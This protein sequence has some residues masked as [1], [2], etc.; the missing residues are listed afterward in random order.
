MCFT[1]A[2][3]FLVFLNFAR[4]YRKGGLRLGFV[5]SEGISVPPHWGRGIQQAESAVGRRP[6]RYE[7]S[8]LNPAPTYRSAGHNLCN[9]LCP[10]SLHLSVHLS[11]GETL[12]VVVHC[13]KSCGLINCV[14][15]KPIS[16]SIDFSSVLQSIRQSDSRD[17]VRAVV[18][19]GP[20]RYRC[21]WS[22]CRCGRAYP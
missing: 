18:V 2:F 5:A 7:R 11:A 22:A 1:H 10:K 4:A 13:F 12:Y 21:V 9:L 16:S 15:I 19:A 14:L 17:C 20:S 6:E 3:S 8:E